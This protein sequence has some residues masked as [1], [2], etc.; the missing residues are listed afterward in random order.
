MVGSEW[1]TPIIVHTALDSM[2]GIILETGLI[3]G[4]CRASQAG[5]D[6]NT[7]DYMALVSYSPNLNCDDTTLP[8][9]Y[10]DSTL[11]RNCNSN[12]SHLMCTW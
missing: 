8:W 3:G 11:I 6:M 9:V 10:L 2:S 5:L 7:I 4:G 12:M 1:S